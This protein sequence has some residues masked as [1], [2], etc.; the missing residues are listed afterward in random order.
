MTGDK[1]VL[2]YKKAFL[3]ILEV[4]LNSWIPKYEAYTMD[5]SNSGIYGEL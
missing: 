5:Q 4:I 1:L 3:K 2:N